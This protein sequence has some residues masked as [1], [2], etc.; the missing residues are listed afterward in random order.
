MHSWVYSLQLQSPPGLPNWLV[1]SSSSL[2]VNWESL[3]PLVRTNKRNIFLPF[4]LEL[5]L[6]V[7]PNF[8]QSIKCL[9]FVCTCSFHS[10]IWVAWLII[11]W[12]SSMM[13]VRAPNCISCHPK[14][15]LFHLKWCLCRLHINFIMY[16]SS[17]HV[18]W[19]TFFL[20]GEGVSNRI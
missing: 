8:F 11:F 9:H 3:W 12:R 17:Q 14:D 10:L 4:Y 13:Q 16:F 18:P 15:M 2:M 6:G 1:S 20:G 5:I 7:L 19:Q